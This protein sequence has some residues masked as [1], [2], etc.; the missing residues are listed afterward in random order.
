MKSAIRKIISEGRTAEI[1]DWGNGKVLKLFHNWCPPDWAE[2][3]AKITD[4]VYKAG[5]PVPK[6]FETIE[7]NGRPGIVFEKIVGISMLD[8][9]IKYPQHAEEYGH[10]LAQLHQDIHNTAIE[11]LPDLCPSLVKSVNDAVVLS[12]DQKQAI[13]RALE[14]QAGGNQVC[15]MDFHPDQVLITKQGPRIIDWETA[16]QGN[17]LADVARTSLILRI[18][19]ISKPT[20]IA[21]QD[22]DRM[23]RAFFSAYMDRYFSSQNVESPQGMAIWNLVAAIARL[24][25]KIDGEARQLNVIIEEGIRVRSQQLTARQMR[26]SPSER[27]KEANRKN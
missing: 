3:E 15:H 11:S 17:P 9:C 12:I 10:R 8:F 7:W 22:F 25:E 2:S 21:K 24:D 19:Q 20:G 13:V 26:P 4:I 27:Q 14:K 16:R 1:Y 6:V 23:R 5:L 18:G